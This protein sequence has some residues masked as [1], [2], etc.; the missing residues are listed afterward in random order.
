ML[1]FAFRCLHRS[2]GMLMNEP[3]ICVNI[4]IACMKLH[5]ICRKKN[6]PLHEEIDEDDDNLP[7]QEGHRAPEGIQ[8]R[9]SLINQRFTNL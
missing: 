7:L 9:Q 3:D 5:N 8:A 1:Y 2:G 4:I 6:I